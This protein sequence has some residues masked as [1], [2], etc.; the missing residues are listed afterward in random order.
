MVASPIL[1][2]ALSLLLASVI[3]G[4]AGAYVHRRAAQLARLGLRGRR[5]LSAAITLGILLFVGS[6][7]L[8]RWVP[9]GAL[10]PL[11]VAGALVAVAV[12]VAAIL[13]AVIDLLVLTTTRA[14][15]AVR[16]LIPPLASGSIP[17]E[18]ADDPLPPPPVT[19]RGFLTQAATGSALAVGAGSSVYGTLFGRHDYVIEDLVVRV[20]GLDRR[21][22][23]YTLVQLSDIHLGL[24]V[25]EREMRAAEDLVRRARPDLVVLT[26]DLIDHDPSHQDD[27]GRLVRRLSALARGGVVAVPGNHDYYTGIGGVLSTLER[28]G[29]VVLRNEGRV[30]EGAAGGFALLGVDDQAAGRFEGGRGGPDLEA[31]LAALPAAADLPRVLL[32]HNPAYFPSAAG[33]VALQLSGHTHGG[34]VNLGVRPADLV[35]GHPYVAG[36]YERAGTRLYVN[37]GF[38]TAGPPTRVG[39]APEVTRIVLTG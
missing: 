39:A 15:A 1:R 6:R 28:A 27:L 22:D 23:G 16:R 12:F 35:L 4:L 8:E 34:Q 29:A 32:C 11:G 31:A 7:L 38:G 33:K 18:V 5:A 10:E 2:L 36:P 9:A 3:V 26:G 13:L 19:R 37:R 24:F 21:L 30:I 17:I 14:G 20:P 25:G